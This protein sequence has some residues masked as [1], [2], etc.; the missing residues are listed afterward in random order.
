MD[1]LFDISMFDS[2]KEDN[3]REVKKANGG[4]PVSLWETYSSMANTYGGVIIL[5]VKE[6]DDNHWK[7]TGL[8][9]KEKLLDDF[10]SQIHNENKV[11][12]NLLTEKDIEVY[13]VDEDVV[14]AIHVP[15]AKREDRPV[16]I[17]NDVFKG[18]YKRA[19]T[20]DYHCSRLQVKSMLRDQIDETMDMVVIEEMD[21]SVFNVDSLNAYRNRHRLFRPD[22]TWSHLDNEHYLEMIGGAQK[23]K[24]GQLHPTVAGLMMFGNEYKITR[25]YP[26][27]FL[28]YREMLDPVIRWTDRLHSTSGEWSGN[29]FDFY[30]RVYHKMIRNVKIP[31]KLVEDTR[32]DDTPV[33][34]AI[35]EA[36]V[37]CIVNSD[38]FIPLGIVIRQEEDSLILENPGNIRVG[39]YRMKYGGISDS[40]NKALMKM[41]NLIGIGERAGSGVPQL[42]SVWNQE[43]WVEPI[44]EEWIEPYE[45]TVLR[46]SFKKKVAIKIG[47]KKMAINNNEIK[48]TLKTK[49]H[50]EQ[51]LSSMEKDVWYKS[52][53]ILN[54]V[55]LK[56][57]RLK[58]LLNNLVDSKQ[59]ITEGINKSKRYK[60]I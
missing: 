21:M 19:H 34:K 55:D 44:I 38:F 5:G 37:N 9:D 29:L 3:R 40:R 4:L 51:I 41:F 58:V 54:F 60:K 27:Y 59:L 43:G 23:G 42:F 50:Y 30:F 53:E 12:I 52:S 39:K 26:E 17:N 28:D 16:Y 22:H 18:T 20:G 45:R 25:Y 14:I 46:L 7:T 24:D 48:K 33:H 31:F 57:S 56:I 11:S 6:I 32:V 1:A 2:Y 8:K 15:M 36:L 35:R 49:Q 13:E 10:W 47:D